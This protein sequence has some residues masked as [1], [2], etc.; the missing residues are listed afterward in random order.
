MT[1]QTTTDVLTR[2]ADIIEPYIN[3]H[4]KRRYRAEIAARMLHDGGL[5]AGGEPGRS[6][7][8][9]QEQAV[10]A[11]QCVQPWKVAEKIAAELAEAGLL[12]EGS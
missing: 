10:N 5:L 8:P 6:T 11:L 1:N 4:F 2:A 3:G 9:V 7:L 12:R